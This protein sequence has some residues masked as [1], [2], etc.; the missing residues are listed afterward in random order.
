MN[1]NIFATA[2]FATPATWQ[3]E[4]M[5]KVAKVAAVAVAKNIYVENLFMA[6]GKP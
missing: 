1:F 4:R 5:Q 2:T 3:K 6:G